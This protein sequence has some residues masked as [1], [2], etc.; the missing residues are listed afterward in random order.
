MYF[1][2]QGFRRG[3]AETACFCFLVSEVSAREI[4]IP[5]HESDCWRLQ[6]S[7]D[8]SAYRSGTW[9]EMTWR[10]GSEFSTN[11]ILA[12]GLFMWPE[13]TC[14]MVATGRLL[15]WWLW[16]Y[17]CIFQQQKK[18]ICKAHDLLWHSPGS[19][20]CLFCWSILS[21]SHPNSS[22]EEQISYLG[23]GDRGW[24]GDVE[25]FQSYF[26]YLFFK[27]FKNYFLAPKTFRIGV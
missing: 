6:S 7:G 11:Q 27:F 20:F 13:L 15:M 5:G 25:E 19:H 26:I 24:E 10:L 18:E 22:G 17:E 23:G 2:G 12:H 1:V 3:S 21:E 9:T 4:W 8:F 14:S 16:A